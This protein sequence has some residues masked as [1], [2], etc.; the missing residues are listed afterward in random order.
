[1][2]SS[3]SPEFATE[4]QDLLMHPPEHIPYEVLKTELTKHT[5][6]SEQHRIKELLSAEKLGDHIPS[7]VLR[8]IL[9]S[10]A[11]TMDTTLMREL[12]LQRLP[13]NV[14]MVIT[15]SAE[16]LSLDQIMQLANRIVEA[17]PAP[18]IA[19]TD[20][21]KQLTAQGTDLSH[22]FEK[23]ATMLSSTINTFSLR[24]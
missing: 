23:L 22:H 7:Q 3:L 20:T 9:G 21:N 16:A 4:V 6:A 13:P 12:F 14:R 24:P 1:M 2:V 5:S 15:A 19:A 18:T 11:M 8:H 17:S 10:M